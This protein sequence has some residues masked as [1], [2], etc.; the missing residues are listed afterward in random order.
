MARIG[1]NDKDHAAAADDLAMFTNSLYAGSDF[2]GSTPLHNTPNST[3]PRANQLRVLERGK[4]YQYKAGWQ[5]PSRPPN[6]KIFSVGP[7][8][9]RWI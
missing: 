2:H 1:A 4:V 6:K 3:D 8:D 5:I 9:A 7:K